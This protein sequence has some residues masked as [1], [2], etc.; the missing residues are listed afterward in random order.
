MVN[1]HNK[2]LD[3]TGVLHRIGLLAF[4]IYS[5]LFYYEWTNHGKRVVKIM[6][7]IYTVGTKQNV[8]QQMKQDYWSLKKYKK[9]YK[10][11][12]IAQVWDTS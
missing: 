1:H 4:F 10:C 11:L 5:Y 2:T 9:E 7:D 3:W 8:L 12:D 6:K